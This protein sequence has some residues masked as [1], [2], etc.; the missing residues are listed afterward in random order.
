MRP[1]FAHAA[2]SD[3]AQTMCGAALSVATL[4]LTHAPCEFPRFVFGG[5]VLCSDGVVRRSNQIFSYVCARAVPRIAS[6][7]HACYAAVTRNG[8]VDGP[9][10]R[11]GCELR[12]PST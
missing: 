10:R 1:S 6:A 11:N 5:F 12:W 2:A 9:K 3:G 4:Q 7:L 8:G